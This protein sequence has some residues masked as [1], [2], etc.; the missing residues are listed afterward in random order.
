M[1]HVLDQSRDACARPADLSR[2][3][4]VAA[5]TSS[6]D[7]GI[8]R[9]ETTLRRTHTVTLTR[10]LLEPGNALLRDAVGGRR[11]LVVLSPSIQRLYEGRVRAYFAAGS[12]GEMPT[13]M[14]LGHAESSKSLR[15]AVEVCERATVAGLGRTS[16]IVA[17]GGGVCSDICGLA[18][19]IHDRGIPHIKVPTTLIGLVDA[20]IATKNAVNHAGRKS[21]LGSFYPPE[22][23][24]LDLDFLATLPRRHI[25]GGIA[26]IIK[27]AAVTNESLFAQLVRDALALIASS[28]QFPAAAA[29]R[30]VSLAAIGMLVELARN[31]F[32]IGDFRRPMD[33]GHT[34]SPYFEVASSY[35]ILHGEA[36]AMDMALS[37]Q[38]GGELGML[39]WDDAD[40]IISLIEQ[41]GLELTWAGASVD[42][43]WASLPSVEQ[44]RNG[45]L[46]LV[47]PTRIG[48]CDY[49]GM[50]MLSPQLLRRCLD[51]LDARAATHAR[52]QRF[53]RG[54]DW[55]PL[56]GRVARVGGERS[57]AAGVDDDEDG[58][59][60]APRLVRGPTS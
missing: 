7:G 11:A 32:E 60:G 52:P 41:V 25:V 2:S 9:F 49:V 37:C 1:K 38:I 23:S 55:M 46:H 53:D 48:S 22:H 17:I 27:L 44:H 14:V 12:H 10:D 35:A 16:P 6:D 19:A 59:P 58:E 47:V 36:V 26:E 8:L 33:F 21:A 43:L 51:Q 18:A 4:G 39:S 54:E 20:G 50:E 29:T 5:L 42:D 24:L 30:V 31:P 28:F 15:A 40:R 45:D 56:S 57:V 34:F 13:F 3:S